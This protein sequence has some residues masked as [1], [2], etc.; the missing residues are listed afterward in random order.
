MHKKMT[1]SL[2]LFVVRVI[3][4]LLSVRIVVVVVICL[5]FVGNLVDIQSFRYS[6]NT[7]SVF[8]IERISIKGLPIYL[9]LYQ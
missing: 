4:L 1:S 2:T 5:A 6:Q 7:H 3:R 9:D 8:Q